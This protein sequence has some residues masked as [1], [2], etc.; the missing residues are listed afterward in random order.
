MIDSTP[1]IAH[2][3]QLSLTL[4]YVSISRNEVEIKE[5]FLGF[6]QLEEKDASSIAIKVLSLLEQYGLP[7]ENC[8]GQSY[9]NTAVMA[10]A[11]SGA[12]KQ[13]LGVNPR[14]MFVN[15]ENHTLNLA[16]LHSCAV[17]PRV[18]TFFSNCSRSFLFLHQDGQY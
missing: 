4:R 6:F 18:T 16:C 14:A 2:E 11:R 5:V 13:I 1:D 3:D 12:Q 15:C 9:D 7:I 10:G 8:H 17:E